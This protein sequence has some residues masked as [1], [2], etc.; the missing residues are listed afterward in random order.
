MKMKRSL[1]VVLSALFMAVVLVAGP[2]LAAEGDQVAPYL[3]PGMAA[4]MK[5]AMVSVIVKT[6]DNAGNLNHFINDFVAKAAQGGA[7]LVLFPEMA[8][9]GYMQPDPG[10]AYTS[11]ETIPGPS[12]NKLIDAAKKFKVYIAMGMTEASSDFTGYL[13]NTM[14]LVGPEGLVGKYRK[15]SIETFGMFDLARWGIAPGR[16]IPVFKLSNGWRVGLPICYDVWM[17]EIPRVNAV[18]GADLLLIGSAGPK[19]FESGWSLVNTVR[20]L[21]NQVGLAYANLAGTYYGTTF[22]GGRMAVDPTGTVVLPMEGTADKE[23]ISYATFKATDIYE[24]RKGMPE[25]RDRIPEAYQALVAPALYPNL[26][27]VDTAPGTTAIYPL[28]QRDN[29]WTLMWVFI[30][31]AIVFGAATLALFICYRRRST[32]K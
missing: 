10:Q 11:A 14:V 6:G 31:L 9:S 32:T 27:P 15:V 17:P 20:A 18:K 3:P 1:L 25:L 4:T 24:A 13:Y 8:L 5:V 23:G 21:E 22:F 29:T 2:V 16:E 30:V 28:P 19:G 26:K 12:V 7:D